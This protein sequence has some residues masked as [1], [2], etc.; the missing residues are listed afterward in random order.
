MHLLVFTVFLETLTQGNKI[1]LSAPC[2]IS[3]TR[4]YC[5]K[6]QSRVCNCDFSSPELGCTLYGFISELNTFNSDVSLGGKEI[7]GTQHSMR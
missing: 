2:I 5:F 4:K 1:L 3:E 6:E 7:T